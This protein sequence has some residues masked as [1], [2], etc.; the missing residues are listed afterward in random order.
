[1]FICSHLS[2]SRWLNIGISSLANDIVDVAQ[3]T[4]GD[5]WESGSTVV[6]KVAVDLPGSTEIC[7]SLDEHGCRTESLQEKETTAQRHALKMLMLLILL[8]FF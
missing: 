7:R 3:R 4:L 6:G 8:V 1:M 5:S 2:L